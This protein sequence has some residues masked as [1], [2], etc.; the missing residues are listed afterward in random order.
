MNH[1]PT[2]LVSSSHAGRHNLMAAAWSMPLDFTPAKVCV[3]I[4]KSTL[5]RKLVEASGEF[6]LAV[7]T[8]GFAAQ[9]LA[10]GRTSGADLAEGHDKF[11][12][13]GLRWFKGAQAA[14]LPEG[15]TAWLECTVI[16]EP[17]NQQAYDLFIGEVRH[18]WA[19]ERVFSGGHWNVPQ[20]LPQH[21]QS[22]HYI[23]GGSFFAASESFSTEPQPPCT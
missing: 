10:V 17:H 16:A 8:R 12:R 7:P 20:D 9:A 21:L 22:I 15:C 11:T 4:D 14:P 2:V 1:G 3:V 18:A 5:T 23:A 19:D 6:T 13:Y